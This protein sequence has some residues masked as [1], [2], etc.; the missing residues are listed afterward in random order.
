M[1]A[2]TSKEGEENFD[3]KCTEILGE[4]EHKDGNASAKMWSE[5]TKGNGK[6]S[7][8]AELVSLGSMVKN[9]AL[10]QM[11]EITSVYEFWGVCIVCNLQV[12]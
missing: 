8:S 12:S 10:L 5:E 11:G 3:Y 9:W 6:G 4:M 7:H 1:D 2:E